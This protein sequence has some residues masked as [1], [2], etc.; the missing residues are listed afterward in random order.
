MLTTVGSYGSIVVHLKN[1]TLLSGGLFE[2]EV[3]KI[4]LFAIFN[5]ANSPLFRV[6]TVFQIENY[7]ATTINTLSCTNYSSLYYCVAHCST[8][9]V[10]S[11]HDGV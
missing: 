7:R 8:V 9:F 3:F 4:A 11:S 1:N 10:F 5:I 2:N 6:P